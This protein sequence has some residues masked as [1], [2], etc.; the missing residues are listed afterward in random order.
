MPKNMQTQIQIQAIF[1]ENYGYKNFVKN[2]I[3]NLKNRC[4]SYCYQVRF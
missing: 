3:G 2:V 1:E 4:Q